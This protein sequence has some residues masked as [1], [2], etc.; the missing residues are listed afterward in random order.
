MLNT[1]FRKKRQKQIRDF[2]KINAYIKNII[3]ALALLMTS[4]IIGIGGFMI[5]DDFT[6]WQAFYMTVITLSTVGFGEVKALSEAGQIFTSFLIIFNI[7]VF[8]YAISVIS[9]FLL[10]GELRSFFKD[11]K[12]FKKINKMENHII[13]CGYG[14]HGNEICEE[15][16]KNDLAFVVIE[17]DP[18]KIE[19]LRALR[20]H[21]IQG[22]ATDDEVLLQAGINRAR[23]IVITYN[24]SSLNVYTVLSARQLNPSLKIVTRAK[25]KIAE[26]K[27]MR[28]G[29]SHVVLTEVIGGFYMATLILQPNVIEFFQI[30]SNMGDAPIHFREIHYDDIKDEFHN[31]SIKDLDLRARTGVNIIGIRKTDGKYEVNPDPEVILTKGMKIIVLGDMNQIKNFEDL[32]LNMLPPQ[33][34]MGNVVKRI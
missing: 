6:F 4:T 9:S 1:H 31:I 20:Y 10:E 2:E 25:D 22:D 14:R 11:Y 5:I 8:A 33:Q 29:A 3:F 16:L 26:K 17:P 32:A 21:F 15:F 23:A 7:G 24:E 28:A 18:V 13:V 12:M 19:K 27:L 30:V 34:V